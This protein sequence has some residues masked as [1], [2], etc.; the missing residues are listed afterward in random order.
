MSKDSLSNDDLIVIYFFSAIVEKVKFMLSHRI[1]YCHTQADAREGLKTS[2][3]L[4]A[5][6]SIYAEQK[7]K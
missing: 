2:D 1:L 4:K 5:G 3:F 6:M 7:T